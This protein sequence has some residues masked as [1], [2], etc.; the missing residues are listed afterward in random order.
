MADSVLASLEERFRLHLQHKPVPL[1]STPAPA[2]SPVLPDPSSAET[3]MRKIV[4]HN[5]RVAR[6]RSVGEQAASHASHDSR[7]IRRTHE[8]LERKRARQLEARQRS[9]T[10]RKRELEYLASRKPTDAHSEIDRALRERVAAQRGSTR[11]ERQR[12]LDRR[13]R[14]KRRRLRRSLRH[15]EQ[16]ECTFRPALNRRSVRLVSGLK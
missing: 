2:P 12:H 1:E 8:A 9:E 10:L 16:H 14:R 13:A 4:R 3:T 15:R 7:I 11:M 6:A 5:Q